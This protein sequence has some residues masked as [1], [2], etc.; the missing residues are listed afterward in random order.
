[1]KCHLCGTPAQSDPCAE[2]LVQERETRRERPLNLAL[3]PRQHEPPSILFCTGC[4]GLSNIVAF[5]GRTLCPDCWRA[6]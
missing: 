2:C 3:P 4:G 1:M 5:Q 6:A